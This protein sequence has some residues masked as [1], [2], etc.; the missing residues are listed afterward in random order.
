MSFENKVSQVANDG[1]GEKKTRWLLPL[2]VSNF[3][4]GERQVSPPAV[5]LHK[6]LKASR[7]QP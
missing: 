6:T 1:R 2:T 4:S 3:L 5:K 7:A